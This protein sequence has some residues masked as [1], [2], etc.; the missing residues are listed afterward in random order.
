V[1]IRNTHYDQIPL[2]TVQKIVGD[3]PMWSESRTH[4]EE[5]RERTR[6]G[7]RPCRCTSQKR[8]DGISGEENWRDLARK[9]QEEPDP[10]RM[11]DLVQRLIERLDEERQSKNPLPLSD[12]Q[13]WKQA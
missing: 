12:T 5:H 10:A 9:I 7:S 6:P 2:T 11:I 3:P 1:R 8:D 4:D 13:E